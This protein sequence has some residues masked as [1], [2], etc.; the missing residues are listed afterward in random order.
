VRGVG[1]RPHEAKRNKFA[2]SVRCRAVSGQFKKKHYQISKHIKMNKKALK[3]IGII[4]SIIVIVIFL[5]FAL[6]EFLTGWNNPK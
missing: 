3:I 5:D 6:G 4:V 1:R 2:S